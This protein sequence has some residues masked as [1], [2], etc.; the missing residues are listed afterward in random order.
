MST[1]LGLSGQYNMENLTE[2]HSWC[3]VWRMVLSLHCIRFRNSKPIVAATKVKC[4]VKLLHLF[5]SWIT[6]LHLLFFSSIFIFQL[7]IS[8]NRYSFHTKPIIVIWILSEHSHQND[9]RKFV[10][11]PGPLWKEG[12]WRYS[13][14]VYKN[15]DT[16]DTNI[17]VSQSRQHP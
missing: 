1:R 16:W 10:S 6:H 4:K 8:T 7:P 14:K 13:Q 2:D 11:K 12:K 5:L 15:K 3:H 17:S 9:S